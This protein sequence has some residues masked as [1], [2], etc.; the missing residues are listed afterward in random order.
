LM[1]RIRDNARRQATALGVEIID[2]RIRRADLPQQNLQATFQRMQ[3]ER[4]REAADE[5]ARGE[6]AAQRVRANADRQATELVSE[7]Q[8]D[9]DIIRGAADAERNKIFADAFGRDAEF[10]AFYRSL[11]AYE[12]ALQGNNSTLVITP[13]SEFFEFFHEGRSDA[14]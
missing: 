1:T 10:F 9:S 11:S 5:R 3:T 4:E 2:V 13:D 12:T 8:R 6:E 14:P 7:A